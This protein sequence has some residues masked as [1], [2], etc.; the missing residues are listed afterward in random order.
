MPNFKIESNG[1]PI[2][3]YKAEFVGIEVS[4]HDKYGPGLKWTFAVTEGPQQ[5]REAYRTA[6]TPLSPTNCCGKFLAALKGERPSV[7]LV[8]NPDDFVGLP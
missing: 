8:V 7:D 4:K 2:G 5:G 3:A 1:L 6:T